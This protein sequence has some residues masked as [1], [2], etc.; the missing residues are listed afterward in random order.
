M[1]YLVKARCEEVAC[2]EDASVWPQAILLHHVLVVHLR[3]SVGS[4]SV[5]G[6]LMSAADHSDTARGVQLQCA[7]SAAAAAI[8]RLKYASTPFCCNT[9]CSASDVHMMHLPTTAQP[10]SCCALVAAARARFTAWQYT[11]SEHSILPAAT[12]LWHCL[13]TCSSARLPACA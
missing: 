8:A 11:R 1:H 13:V 4:M 10:S 2:S 5:A 7:G 12:T 3:C 9:H 6:H